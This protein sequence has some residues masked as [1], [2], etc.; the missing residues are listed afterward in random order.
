V[1]RL[2]AALA[3]GLAL[4]GLGQAT[5]PTRPP[6]RVQVVAEEYSFALSRRTITSGRAVLE[7]T[8]FGEDPHDLRL[9]RL[10]RGAPMLKLREVEPGQQAELRARLAPGRF[11]LWCSL[12]DHRARGMEARLTVVKRR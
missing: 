12:A 2:G 11:V 10:A 7:L 8:N 5:E 3:A 1:T 9:R 4:T 6:A